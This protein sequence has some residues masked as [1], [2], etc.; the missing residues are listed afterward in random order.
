MKKFSILI[1]ND[2][3]F[4]IHWVEKIDKAIFPKRIAL[5]AFCM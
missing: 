3:S 4:T 5:R 1:L 2:K